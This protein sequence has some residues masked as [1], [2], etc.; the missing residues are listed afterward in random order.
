MLEPQRSS[1]ELWWAFLAA[2]LITLL[3]LFVTIIWRSVPAASGLFGHSIGVLGFVLMLMT[4]TLYSLRKRSRFARW[5]TMKAWLEFHIFTGL[6]GPYM[7]LLHSSWKFHGLAG[8]VMLLTVL[9]VVSGFIGRYIYTAVPRSV[10][11][12]VME[13]SEL[14]R[15]MAVMEEQLHKGAARA[16]QLASQAGAGLLRAAVDNGANWP[17]GLTS[18]EQTSQAAQRAQTRYYK[19]LSRRHKTLRRQIDSLVTA[20]RL[21]AVWHY[22]HIPLGVALFLLAFLHAAGAFYFATLGR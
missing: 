13:A 12:D 2:V 18:S 10:D 5:G 1:R 15:Q 21:L 16:P 19:E 20:R 9:I 4:E 7:V 17:V 11:G 8:V 22:I 14:E 3:Y 6:V